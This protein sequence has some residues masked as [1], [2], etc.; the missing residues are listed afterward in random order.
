MISVPDEKLWLMFILVSD[1]THQLNKK[2]Y[3]SQYTIRGRY[4]VQMTLSQKC[5]EKTGSFTN[6]KLIYINWIQRNTYRHGMHISRINFDTANNFYTILVVLQ[7]GIS[8]KSACELKNGA[9]LQWKTCLWSRASTVNDSCLVAHEISPRIYS[10][11]LR[12]QHVE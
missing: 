3:S 8:P 1:F 11:L 6:Y 4:Q 12:Q 9:K 2:V 5:F 10:Q 7:I